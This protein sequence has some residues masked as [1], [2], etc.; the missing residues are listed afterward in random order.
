MLKDHIH[1]PRQGFKWSIEMIQKEREKLFNPRGQFFITL[2][3]DESGEIL[4]H[5]ELDN[6]ITN[7]GGVFAAMLF[8]SLVT[9][10]PATTNGGLTMLAVGTGATGAVNNPDAPDPRQRSLNSE[11]ERKTFSLVQF[12]ASDGS[13]SAVPTNV[14]DF[15]T[16]YATAEAVG[17]LNEMG[18]MRTVSLNPAVTNPNPDVFPTYDPTQDLNN[19]DAMVNYLTFPVINKPNTAILTITW[20]LTF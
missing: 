4:E 5:H 8:S 10:T 13:V 6:I 14:V 9:P 7:D 11:I 1:R 15:T 17:A 12:R 19:F 18:L 16:T 3:D 2:T 20:R